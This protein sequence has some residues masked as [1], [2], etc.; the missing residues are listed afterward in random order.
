MAS[1]LEYYSAERGRRS[2][3]IRYPVSVV[4]ACRSIS[5]GIISERYITL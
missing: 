3:D 2:F 4:E 5:I 1:A